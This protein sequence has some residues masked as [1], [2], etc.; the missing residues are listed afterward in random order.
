MP[1]LAGL[2]AGAV[3]FVAVS[4]G[5]LPTVVLLVLATGLVTAAPTAADLAHR[6]AVNVA[7]LIGLTPVLW[8]VPWPVRFNHGALLLALAAGWVTGALVADVRDRGGVPRSRLLLHPTHLLIPLGGLAAALATHRM[9][10][11]RPR[12]AL[13]ALLPGGDNWTHFNMFSTI[14][15]LGAVP[16]VRATAPDGSSWAFT[17]YPRGFHAL[18]ASV[19][20][21]M[22]PGLHAGPELLVAYVQGT[23]VVIAMGTVLVVATVLTVPGLRDRPAI[24]VPTVA[25]TLTGLLWEPGQKVLANG[26]ANFWLAAVTAGCAVVLA[27]MSGRRDAQGSSPAVAALGVGALMV[28]VCHTWTPLVLVALPAG[29]L[30]MMRAIRPPSRRGP[31]RVAEMWLPLLALVG[32]A[33]LALEALVIVLTTVSVSDVVLAQSGY[34]GTSPVP[35]LVFLLVVLLLAALWPQVVDRDVGLHPPT[36]GDVRLSALGPLLGVV[37]LT[38]LLVLQV[39]AVGTSSYYFL[40]F[41]VGF[42]LSL[43]VICPALV[44]TALVAL[45]PRRGWRRPLAAA[46]AVAAA[47]VATQFFGHVGVH[48]ALLFS[49]TDDGTI[50]LDGGFNRE[51]IVDGIL[52]AA[53]TPG[54]DVDRDYVALGSGNTPLLYYPDAWFHAVTGSTSSRVSTRLTALNVHLATADATAPVAR[55]LLMGDPRLRLVASAD[56]ADALRQALAD[57]ALG[58]RIIS[59]QSH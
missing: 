37:A 41:L 42:E 19:A 50:G 26:F 14:E 8:W 11:S 25:L 57:P 17:N 59:W 40:K 47:L 3:L 20:D 27:L 45:V 21:L 36:A 9:W 38:G 6:I 28:G 33:L 34:N 15:R 53:A 30:V 7:V 31:A 18:V 2:V 39:R 22:H 58:S 4:A 48:D 35:T 56:Q 46:S 52:A 23:V 1:V 16:G 29:V 54:H 24:A 12:E 10:A 49:T 43:A 5:W 13:L 44:A 55:R 32:C 51:A